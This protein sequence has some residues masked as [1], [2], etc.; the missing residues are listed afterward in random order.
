M[1]RSV[2]IHQ[3]ADVQSQTIGEGTRIWQ[4]VVILPQAKIG[5][6]VNICSHCFIENDV[7]IGDR[8]TIKSGVQLWDGLRIEQDV[9]IG[10][11]VTFT[12]DKFP[13]S[14]Q[15]PDKFLQTHIKKGASIGAGAVILPGITI[16]EGAMIGA[17]AIVTKSVPPYSVVIG[18]A[19]RI[20]DHVAVTVDSALS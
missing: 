18:V 5:S 4:F 17:G 15:Y 11:N 7:I 20:V 6:E 3:T 10:P 8:V 2:V 19:S 16:G 14:K 13:R 12:N 1:N 9:F